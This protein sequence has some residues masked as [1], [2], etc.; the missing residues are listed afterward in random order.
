[1]STSKEANGAKLIQQHDIEAAAR[2]LGQEVDI[3]FLESDIKAQQ[4]L[5]AKVWRESLVGLGRKLT[6]GR[7]EH[8]DVHV[9][10]FGA[11]TRDAY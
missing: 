9:Q 8:A 7:T 11:R 1:M 6:N 2:D 5:C 3:R 4:T 10:R